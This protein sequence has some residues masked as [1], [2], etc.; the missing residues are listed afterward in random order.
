MD[1]YIAAVS[2]CQSLLFSSL[3]CPLGTASILE[4]MAIG[5]VSRTTDT[6][7]KHTLPLQMMALELM[8]DVPAARVATDARAPTGGVR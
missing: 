7:T 8:Q 2:P 3:V 1:S 6:D 5:G 4:G